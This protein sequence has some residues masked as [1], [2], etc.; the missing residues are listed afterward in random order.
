MVLSLFGFLLAAAVT[1]GLFSVG[2]LVWRW[3][4]PQA[5][6]TWHVIASPLIGLGLASVWLN[7]VGSLFGWTAAFISWSHIALLSLYFYGRFFG[8][9]AEDNDWPLIK[10]Y[11]LWILLAIL[12]LSF[13]G[14][15]FDEQWHFPFATVIANGVW[16]TPLIFDPTQA[17]TYHYGYDIVVAFIVR[18]GW[19]APF[20]SDVL[21]A[22]LQACLLGVVWIFLRACGLSRKLGAI[23]LGIVFFCG[24]LGWILRPLRFLS[25]DF[26]SKINTFT[27]SMWNPIFLDTYTKSTIFALGIV[28]LVIAAYQAKL[29]LNVKRL[30][31]LIPIL[32]AAVALSSETIFVFFLP[33]VI[34]ALL[35]DPIARN[36]RLKTILACAIG[37][38][39][40]VVQGGLITD[41]VR[42]LFWH[43]QAAADQI[44]NTSFS[45]R[46]S[47]EFAVFG[48]SLDLFSW[49]AYV[50]M[51]VEFGIVIIFGLFAWFAFPFKNRF[52]RTLLVGAVACFLVPFIIWYGVGPREM[53]RVWLPAFAIFLPLG[54]V[55]VLS[56]RSKLATGVKVLA[57]LAIV[58]G[59]SGVV[60]S[61][62]PIMATYLNNPYPTVMSP[63]LWL[64]SLDHA[65]WLPT[66]ST[67][68]IETH[69]PA[70]EDGASTG[71][72]RQA[73]LVFGVPVQGCF[74]FFRNTGTECKDFVDDPS[75]ETLK[76]LGV[77]HLLLT[78]GFVEQHQAEQWFASLKFV[79]DYP[80]PSWVYRLP[81]VLWAGKDSSYKL[82]AYQP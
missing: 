11:G 77:T 46:H 7:S 3:L 19:P 1:L 82:Y 43:A 27:G 20:A 24:T 36:F 73:P 30:L 51:F 39:I 8:R 56:M 12:A 42:G 53:L 55:A 49:S 25:Q 15:I 72:V 54:A 64:P 60:M 65:N 44:Q 52:Y 45:L 18:A 67:I 66:N 17:L 26:L 69:Y 6:K 29:K 34:L 4:F 47:A 40:V 75:A 63:A 13:F 38:L 21:Q 48:P 9:I 62:L 79:K 81:R 41:A 32:M 50:R 70:T 2:G 58:G 78:N 59:L 10:K 5:S 61:N 57:A 80:I 33:F 23:G 68:W 22:V 76:A 14:G 31:W 37:L 74:N 28:W 71:I 16:P 35:V